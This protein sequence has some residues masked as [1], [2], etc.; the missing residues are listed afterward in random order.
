MNR[1]IKGTIFVLVFFAVGFNSFTQTVEGAYFSLDDISSNWVT[2]IMSGTIFDVFTKDLNV[3]DT[4]LKKKIFL[5][6]DD[7]EIYVQRLNELKNTIRTQGIRSLFSA[8]NLSD[9]DIKSGGFWL[10]IGANNSVDTLLSGNFK[11]S[12]NGFLYEMFSMKNYRFKMSQ[13]FI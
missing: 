13:L 7:A 4:D 12:I 11:F 6:S 9:Y 8:W 3:Y 2:A 1:S 5:Q 10:Y